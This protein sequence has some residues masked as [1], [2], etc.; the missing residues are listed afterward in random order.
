MNIRYSDVVGDEVLRD[1]TKHHRKKKRKTEG[2]REGG[3][4]TYI[5]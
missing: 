5:V 2:R 3:E 1:C 4:Q